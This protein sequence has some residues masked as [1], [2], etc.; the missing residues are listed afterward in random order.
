MIADYTDIKYLTLNFEGYFACRIATDPDPTNEERGLSGYTMA[1]ATEDKLD[2]VIRLQVDDDYIR[3]NLRPPGQIIGMDVNLLNGVQVTSVQ[4]N[5]SDYA[6]DLTGGKV[7]LIGKD[8]IF[9]GPIFESRNNITGSDDDFA[10]VITPF[11]LSIKSNDYEIYA[12]DILDPSAD[13]PTQKIW[14]ITNPSIYGRRLPVSAAGNDQ[15]VNKAINVFDYYGY[16][17]DRKRFMQDEINRYQKLIAQKSTPQHLRDKYELEIEKFKSRIYQL[18]F[19][20]DRVISKIGTKVNW[21]FNINGTKEVNR[22]I[23]LTPSNGQGTT[24]DAT[25]ITNWD[26]PVQFWFGGWDG[27]LLTGYMRGSLNIPVKIKQVK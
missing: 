15:E 25:P 3:K 16:F 18:D 1:L 11:K 17:R 9:K 14:E 21:D 5:G 13:A 4:Y 7:N 2:Q 22:S 26:W 20:G 24:L 8:S 10:F 6:S 23:V 19:W 27:D 12:E